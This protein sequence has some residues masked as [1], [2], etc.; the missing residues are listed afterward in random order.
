MKPC[1]VCTNINS[2][3]KTGKTLE[4]QEHHTEIQMELP[5]RISHIYTLLPWSMAAAA[6]DAATTRISTTFCKDGTILK[7]DFSGK[8]VNL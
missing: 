1:K 8:Y 5:R 6:D 2:T 3:G 7:C 4:R